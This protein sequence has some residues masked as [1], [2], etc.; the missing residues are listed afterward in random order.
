[1][2]IC[3]F[4]AGA[5]GKALGKILIDNHHAVK[6]YDPAIY[7]DVGFDLAT[8]KANGVIIA[9]PSAAM[10]D[11]LANYPEHLKKLPTILATKGLMDE[12]LFQDF[13]QFSII[14]G[15]GFAQEIIDGKDATFTASAPFAMGLLQNHQITIE[16]QE[17]FRGIMLCGALKNIYAIG[18]G[19]YSDSENETA[20]FIQHAHAEMQAYLQDHGADPY[21]AELSCGIGD[22]ILT[23]TNETSRNFTCGLR[24]QQGKNIPEIIEELQTV[25]GLSALNQADTEKY[26]YLREIKSLVDLHR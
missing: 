14:S 16:L 22:L 5:F 18:A 13:S 25:E 21:T 6:Y 15:P 12:S 23:C 17:D 11:F 24:L 8:Y 9:I 10:T 3:I 19:Y 26:M 20:M 1:M 2:I 7:P 4:G